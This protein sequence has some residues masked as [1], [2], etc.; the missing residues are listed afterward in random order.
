MRINVLTKQ[1]N[2]VHACTVCLSAC[3]KPPLIPGTPVY[4]I[5]SMIQSLILR[6][7][8]CS[9]FLL[10]TSRLSL[11]VSIVHLQILNHDCMPL[12]QYDLTRSHCTSTYK[13]SLLKLLS[14]YVYSWRVLLTLHV[15]PSFWLL[16]CVNAVRCH[17]HDCVQ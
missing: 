15:Q 4:V 9:N 5:F 12:H 8:T 7:H 2:R 1:C 3:C 14:A 17:V 10:P 13:E 6:T 16:W 11:F